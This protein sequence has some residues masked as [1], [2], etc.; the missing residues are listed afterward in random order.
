MERTIL[1]QK[2][3]RQDRQDIFYCTVV[4]KEKT[5]ILLSRR[6][7]FIP[8]EGRTSTVDSA[9]RYFIILYCLSDFKASPFLATQSVRRQSVIAYTASNLPLQI[10][11]HYEP[12]YA[13]KAAIRLQLWD[14]S[15][16]T[17]CLKICLTSNRRDYCDAYYFSSREQ[18]CLTMR[19][20]KQYALPKQHGHQII[21][22]FYDDETLNITL[23]DANEPY[24]KHPE[25]AIELEVSLHE[26]KEICIAQHWIATS[27]PNIRFNR[28]TER[29]N[30]GQPEFCFLP[31][32]NE[33]CLLEFYQP[34]CLSAEIV[35]NPIL[36][37]LSKS[38]S[39]SPDD[40]DDAASD[41]L[42]LNQTDL[43]VSATPISNI[44]SEDESLERK[45]W[46]SV[47]MLNQAA[48]VVKYLHLRLELFGQSQ[49]HPHHK[50]CHTMWFMK[51]HHDDARKEEEEGKRD[52][53]VCYNEAKSGVDSFDNLVT[54]HIC[55]GDGNIGGRW[56]CG[57]TFWI[58]KG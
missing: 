34:L 30:N 54:L 47:E 35:H 2:M 1:S 18:T 43:I 39:S 26:F 23:K 13:S 22:K 20:K 42:Q 29:T 48:V 36:V 24:L 41:Y 7:S 56:F 58:A 10:L 4:T 51:V 55:A 44:S 8:V 57:S 28:E 21:T 14:S 11:I 49:Y 25:Y 38:E 12:F 37:E 50:H 32:L 6:Q 15:D 53:V 31:Q 3:L 27:M 5:C 46:Q 9:A 33:M 16:D 17:E 52:I 45:R 19:L 40:F